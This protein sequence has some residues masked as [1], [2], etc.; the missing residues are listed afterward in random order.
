MPTGIGDHRPLPP[1]VRN[2]SPIVPRA[3]ISGRAL[4]L[5]S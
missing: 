5:R 1:T 4:S 3:S 2:M